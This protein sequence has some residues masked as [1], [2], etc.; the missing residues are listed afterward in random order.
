MNDT[1]TTVNV[2]HVYTY[3]WG[4]HP[5][6]RQVRTPGRAVWQAM[7]SARESG[8]TVMADTDRGPR[9]LIW[10]GPGSRRIYCRMPH[11]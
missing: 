8:A 11:A 5:L 10:S 6:A 1:T 3:G 2:G 7:R 9:R 4:S